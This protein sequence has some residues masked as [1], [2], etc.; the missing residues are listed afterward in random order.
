MVIYV[1]GCSISQDLFECEENESKK[2]VWSRLLMNKFTN[3]YS[4]LRFDFN[5][6]ISKYGKKEYINNVNDNILIN[7]SMDGAGNDYIYHTTVKNITSLI[8][9]GMKPNY[10]IIQFS[11]PNRRYTYD[12]SD[13]RFITPRDSYFL[14]SFMLFEP[15]ATEHTFVYMLSL[16]EILTKFNIDYRFFIYFEIDESK[17]KN[18]VNHINQEKIINFTQ[19]NIF[20]GLL[21]YMKINSYTR[22]EP[23]HLNKMGAKFISEKIYKSFFL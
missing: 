19:E 12:G 18:I 4:Y 3:E 13:Y 16:Q 11:G 2:F 1:N 9:K 23:G 7:D 8:E 20:K 14:H 6:L 5:N 21:N 17:N 10:V 22:D 15:I